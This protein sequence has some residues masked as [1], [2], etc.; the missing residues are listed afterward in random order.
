MIVI[1]NVVRNLNILTN[2]YRFLSRKLLRNDICYFF[3]LM[4]GFLV[5]LIFHRFV[6]M[7]SAL[8]SNHYFA[9]HYFAFH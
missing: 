6:K 3:N 5:F 4:R 7:T 8:F 2:M 1:S 9:W